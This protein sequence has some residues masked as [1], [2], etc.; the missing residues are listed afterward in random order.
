MTLLPVGRGV[1]G[2]G[3]GG[4]GWV[5]NA[6]ALLSAPLGHLRTCE[7]EGGGD[8]HFAG[9]KEFPSLLLLCVA[10][11]ASSLS[12]HVCVG[13]CIKTTIIVI[14]TPQT[15]THTQTYSSLSHVSS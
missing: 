15:N 3:A 14:H 5:A 9:L 13:G 1:G 10:Y 2:E 7:W 12:V 11:A 8:P 4:L 6:R